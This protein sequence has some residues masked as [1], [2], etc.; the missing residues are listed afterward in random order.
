MR[1]SWRGYRIEQSIVK[2][3]FGVG[4]HDRALATAPTVASP[5][6]SPPLPAPARAAPASTSARAC[7]STPVVMVIQRTF[8]PTTAY[9]LVITS[10]SFSVGVGQQCSTTSMQTPTSI[11]PREVIQIT[12][13]QI[14]KNIS[15]Q[16]RLGSA[17]QPGAIWL[18]LD[19]T[20]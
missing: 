16:C 13:V 2:G 17:L 3:Q 15:W 7:A 10:G 20:G 18:Q 6:L 8:T 4:I 14:E 5:G 9:A 1:S 12:S 11:L 19:Y